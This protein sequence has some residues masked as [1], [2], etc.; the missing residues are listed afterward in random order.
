MRGHLELPSGEK[1]A[2]PLI[3]GKWDEAM[4]VE[5]ADQSQRLL[6]EKAA[7]PP[8]PTRYPINNCACVHAS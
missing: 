1:L 7:P 8:D 6:W 4:F 2:K 3:Y 5:L